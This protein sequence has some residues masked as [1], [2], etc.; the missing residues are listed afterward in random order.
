MLKGSRRRGAEQSA[1]HLLNFQYQELAPGASAD[2]PSRHQAPSDPRQRV[3]PAVLKRAFILQSF[4]FV[5]KPEAL[6][7]ESDGARRSLESYL[8]D[9]D[10]LVPW[11]WIR[12]VVWKAPF[13][14]FQCPICLEPPTAPRMTS[15]GHIFCF[16]CALRHLNQQK[17]AGVQRT[18]AVCHAFSVPSLLKPCVLQPLEPI[19]VGCT[20]SFTLVA[21]EASSVLVFQRDDKSK[22]D[23]ALAGVAAELLIP[24]YG[25]AS[26]DCG[27]YCVATDELEELLDVMDC[28]GIE[29]KLDGLRA[30]PRP[31]TLDD[32][33]E[34]AAL[35][36]ALSRARTASAE[37]VSPG[38][39]ASAPA[40]PLVAG[41]LGSIPSSPALPQPRVSSFTLA[42][43]AASG[44]LRVVDMFR[45]TNGQQVY[46]HFLNNKMLKEDAAARGQPMPSKIQAKVLELTTV[47]QTEETRSAMRALA[48][49]PL[50]ASYTLA[51]IDLSA[52][53]LPET[54]A[55]FRTAIDR[56]L[57]RLAAIAATEGSCHV[58]ADELW[59]RHKAERLAACREWGLQ[60]TPGVSPELTPALPD[61]ASLPSLELPP[62]SRLS[63]HGGSNH[64]SD[65]GPSDSS[66]ESRQRATKR[67]AAAGSW[68][69]SQGL[70]SGSAVERLFT[71]QKASASPPAPCWGKKPFSPKTQLAGATST[72]QRVVATVSSTH[73]DPL[74]ANPFPDLPSSSQAVSEQKR[75]NRRGGGY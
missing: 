63:D 34:Y 65:Q 21:R 42:R 7:L 17:A 60:R 71:A 43:A 13:D 46:L 66:V 9:H 2:A 33:S 35:T 45:A 61:L 24:P 69:Q 47:T 68:G 6:T 52:V 37:G 4:Q 30:L 67:E 19:R 44:P 27:R 70:S 55:A 73:T 23:A 18:C 62:Q 41:R 16:S 56:R 26:G 58:S 50:H 5:L 49:V 36:D 32:S 38:A 75:K 15:C 57:E 12:A 10:A 40:T 1:N 22:I 8:H 20:A 3:D 29:E 53:V 31:L 64:V 28:S 25:S 39:K 14:D 59:E 11:E 48:H 51:L 72:P 54:M 74:A